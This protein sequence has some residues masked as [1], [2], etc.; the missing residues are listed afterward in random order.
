LPLIGGVC[1]GLRDA[2]GRF[3]GIATLI[4]FFVD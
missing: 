3:T 4:A 1:R 2:F